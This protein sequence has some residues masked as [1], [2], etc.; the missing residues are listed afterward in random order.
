[1][2]YSLFSPNLLYLWVQDCGYSEKANNLLPFQTIFSKCPS[3]I[4]SWDCW[5]Y[6]RWY[7]RQP[8]DGSMPCLLCGLKQ[9]SPG[10]RFPCHLGKWTQLSGVSPPPSYIRLQSSIVD[11]DSPFEESRGS[12]PPPL[13]FTVVVYREHFPGGQFRGYTWL[14]FLTSLL[15]LGWLPRPCRMNRTWPNQA[16]RG[17]RRNRGDVRGDTMRKP[18]AKPKVQHIIQNKSLFS[19]TNQWP[20]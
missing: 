15:L 2:I 10:L 14:H 7:R 19:Q 6:N 16:C 9:F 11:Q 18:L 1:M 13:L 4:Y 3:L 5:L 20:E 12:W 8:V 17:S